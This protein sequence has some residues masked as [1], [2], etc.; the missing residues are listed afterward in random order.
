MYYFQIHT[1]FGWNLLNLSNVTFGTNYIFPLLLWL[2]I[3]FNIA[4]T[5][6]LPNSYLPGTRP[7][8]F[9][10]ILLSHF[11]IPLKWWILLEEG[12][13]H[14]QWTK[15]LQEKKTWRLT[16]NRTYWNEG[17]YG[18]EIQTTDQTT[19]QWAIDYFQERKTVLTL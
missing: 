11:V 2:F 1:G 7:S 16:H 6:N 5:N 19:D 3:Y 9:R 15:Y 13:L 12:L 10:T 8:L 14:M 18:E 17:K 4:L